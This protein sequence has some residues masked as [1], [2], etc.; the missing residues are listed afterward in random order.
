MMNIVLVY[1]RLLFGIEMLFIFVSVGLFLLI[2][3]VPL[4]KNKKLKKESIIARTLG[5]T[6]IFGSIILFTI[7]KFM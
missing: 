7:T 3:D 2:R 4:L 1:I 6:Y 5:Y